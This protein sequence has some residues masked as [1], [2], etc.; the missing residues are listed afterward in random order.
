MLI[1]TILVTS[2]RNQNRSRFSLDCHG[3]MTAEALVS[4]RFNLL[5]ITTLCQ[6]N[7]ILDS[8]TS[9]SKAFSYFLFLLKSCIFSCC[10]AFHWSIK[11]LSFFNFLIILCNSFTLSFYYLTSTL[12]SGYSSTGAGKFKSMK[13]WGFLSLITYLKIS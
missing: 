9:F 12:N 6:Y 1:F 10:L 11:N 7:I 5:V 13:A 8:L 3:M 2:L 4:L